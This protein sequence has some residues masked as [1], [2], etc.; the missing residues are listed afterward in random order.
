M[1]RL[2]ISIYPG[3]S[4]LE[5]NLSYI[6]LAGSLGFK[7]VFTCLISADSSNLKEFKSVCE[8]AHA[9]DME[10]IGDVSPE[11][12]EL[13]DMT[14]YDLKPFSELGFDGIR[15]DLGFSG[16]EESIMT[17]NPYGLKIELNMSNGTKYL[18]NILSYQPLKDNLYGCHNFYPHRYTGLKEDHF[19]SCS[20][21]FKSQ[22]IRT[23]AFVS[24]KS[25][26]FGPWPVDEGLCTLEAHRD[27]D[28]VTQA[29]AL[30]NTGLIDDVIVANCFASEDELK[31]LSEMNLEILELTVE[32]FDGL[33]DVERT[34]VLEEPHFN[35][36]DVSEYMVRSTQ[37]RVKYK[38]ETFDPKHTDDITQ[39][40]ILIDSSL[41]KR[42]A[43]ELQVALKEMKNTGKTSRVGR[44]I[45]EEQFLLHTIRP[46]QKFKFKL[47]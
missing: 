47:K 32:L 40:D 24:S 11:V 27:L 1:R 37:S 38:N 28:I 9:Y 16:N 12:F 6:D 18:E 4:T 19:L 8:K 25:A 31:R 7:R 33:T 44:V 29:K 3:H 26:H 43:G 35:R 39:G 2:G 15:L 22:G 42:Y 13:L 30:F 45:L 46:W 36:G 10:V 41:Y 34:I 17:C 21:Q 14:I 5:E 23:A 20:E